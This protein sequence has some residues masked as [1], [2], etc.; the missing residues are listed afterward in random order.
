MKHRSPLS[1][2]KRSNLM[3]IFTFITMFL[4]ALMVLWAL[5]FIVSL[6]HYIRSGQYQ[7]DQRLRDVC[8]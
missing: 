7:I 5:W 8:K 3:S 2:T 4:F 1:F 6:I